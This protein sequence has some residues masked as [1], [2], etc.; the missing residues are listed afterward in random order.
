MLRKQ[1]EL[2]SVQSAFL[3]VLSVSVR[4]DGFTWNRETVDWRAQ[5]SDNSSLTSVSWNLTWSGLIL[6]LMLRSVLSPVL[7]S[8]VRRALVRRS[9]R[10]S[11]RGLT[12]RL[13]LVIPGRAGPEF[14]GERAAWR[15]IQRIDPVQS[16]IPELRIVC[17]RRQTSFTEWGSLGKG[18]ERQV[19]SPH[20]VKVC[21]AL[22]FTAPARC[23][24]LL[25]GF[26]C[27]AELLSLHAGTSSWHGGMDYTFRKTLI[28]L[29]VKNKE[30]LK[31]GG[32]IQHNVIKHVSNSTSHLV[33]K[34]LFSCFYFSVF[35][36][37]Y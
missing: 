22:W 2:S 11:L 18:E 16:E 35:F 19:S 30:T 14:S 29:K 26:L 23:S 31:P 36:S 1:H 4:T 17:R 32:Q 12:S 8:A 33:C 15:D 13:H 34:W 24:S 37:F 3:H 28:L 27:P 7:S 25:L 6:V 9:A 21:W 10:G 20:C 5:H